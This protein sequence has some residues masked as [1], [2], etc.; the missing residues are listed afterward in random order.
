MQISTF[1]SFF[2]KLS[3]LFLQMHYSHLC[4]KLCANEKLF[5]IKSNS[6]YPKM[7]INISE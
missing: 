7:F 6:E 3:V 2:S 4:L 5:D 1:P